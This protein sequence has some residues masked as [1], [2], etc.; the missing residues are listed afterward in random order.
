MPL[1]TGTINSVAGSASMATSIY[2]AMLAAMP[3]TR[4]EDRTVRWKLCV[5][6]AEGVLGYLDANHA[7]ITVTV[8]AGSGSV[9]RQV[10]FTVQS[11]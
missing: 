3:L 7:Q 1:N 2:N 4:D 6:I 11:V 9:T 5:A 8:P 10:D